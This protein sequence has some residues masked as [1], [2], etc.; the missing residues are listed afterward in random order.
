MMLVTKTIKE[1]VEQVKRSREKEATEEKEKE[2]EKDREGDKESSDKSE[3]KDKPRNGGT[4][5]QAKVVAEEASDQTL[6]KSQSQ[7][8]TV[9]TSQSN[10]PGQLSHQHSQPQVVYAPPNEQESQEVRPRQNSTVEEPFTPVKTTTVSDET[11]C[12]LVHPSN[13]Y[14]YKYR[15]SPH[16]TPPYNNNLTFTLRVILIYFRI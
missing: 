7:S 6:S 8:Q 14:F 5:E 15:L 2:K 12:L 13:L 1:R 3:N 11:P 9:P 10:K 4:E 16:W